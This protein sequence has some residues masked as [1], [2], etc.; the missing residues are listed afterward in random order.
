MAQIAGRKI[1]S[2]L[3]FVLLFAGAA[4]GQ[5]EQGRFVGHI[6]DPTGAVI[7]GATV[8]ARNVATN[9]VQ[10][11]LTND[12]GDFVITPVQAGNYIL[13][14]TATGFQKATTKVIEVQV[15]QIVRQDFDLPIGTANSTVEVTTTTPLLSTDSATSGQVIRTRNLPNFP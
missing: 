4:A 15:G 12:S 10:R 11:A 6:E 3:V 9:I 13:T 5:V 2:F 8:E 14:V 1:A 7:V